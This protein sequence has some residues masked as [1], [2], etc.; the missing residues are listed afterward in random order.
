MIS[1][2]IDPGN[3]QNPDYSKAVAMMFV[4]AAIFFLWGIWWGWPTS[5]DQHDP[6]PRA[7]KM[8][9]NRTFDSGVRYWGAFG[10]QEILLFSVIP[11]TA[12]KKFFGLDPELSTALMYFMTRLLWALHGFGIVALS[13]VT[14]L[15]LLEDKRAALLAAAMVALSPGLIAWAH[16]SQ[17]D[18]AHAFWYTLAVT[19][20]AVGWRRS[21]FRWLWFAAIAA[22][23]T[24]GV[25]Y[26]GG[27]VV[28]APMLAVYLRYP[29]WK[30]SLYALLLMVSALLIFFITTPLASGAPLQ[31]AAEYLA[32]VLANQH[33]ETD[34]PLALW[35]MPGAIWDLLGPG[36]ALLILTSVL[37]LL[38]ARS[39]RY[40]SKDVWLL[41]GAFFIPYYLTLSWQHVA[42]VRYVLPLISVLAVVGGYALSRVLDLKYF[43]RGIVFA[44]GC[45]AIANLTLVIA[46]LSG[47]S[48]DTRVRLA[49]WFE[50]HAQEGDKVETLLNHRPYF[51]ASTPFETKPRPH[52]QAETAE[53]KRRIEA[54]DSSMVYRLQNIFAG[55]A[56]L[57]A[58]TL[59]T[60]VDKER[61]WLEK[62][63]IA[64][65]TGP[66]GPLSRGSR[67]VVVNLNTAHFYVLDWPGV[68]PLSPGEKD[69]F[70]SVLRETGPFRLRA[71]FDPLVPEWLRYPRELWF[72]ISPPVEVYEV[73]GTASERNIQNTTINLYE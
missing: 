27:V 57:D 5:F 65:D 24:A 50:E 47:F 51:V 1:E 20:T 44:T 46:L 49:A 34:H 16:I 42:T 70:L 67:Y 15:T 4:M 45:A 31:W 54:D 12:V 33:R 71:R 7:I 28:L 72:N 36:V 14:S 73:M 10:Y 30:A 2:Q 43:H 62:R 40:A 19:L 6:T 48:S 23:L 18:I 29:G 52:F 8:L 13:W 68:D 25:K 55:W 59:M 64:Y 37:L 39:K 41:T 9:W 17:V 66:Q 60:W 11:V 35:T 22:G 3:K 32:D 56:G 26:I 58:M 63:A 61:A 69:F 53:M 21:S 38:L